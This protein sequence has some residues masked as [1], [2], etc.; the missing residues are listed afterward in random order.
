MLCCLAFV[1]CGFYLKLMLSQYLPLFASCGFVFLC[2]IVDH[3]RIRR[4]K[5]RN[6][7]NKCALCC[8]HL[9]WINYEEV[10]IARGEVSRTMLGF[11]RDAHVAKSASLGSSQ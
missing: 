5:K 4:A 2:L 7:N 9:N 8:A 3:C 1:A 10:A 11:A 6:S